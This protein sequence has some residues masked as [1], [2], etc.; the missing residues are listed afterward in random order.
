[1]RHR[2]ATAATL[3]IVV[4]AFGAGIFAVHAAEAPSAGTRA[5]VDSRLNRLEAE[6]SAAEDV[7][8]I[9]RLQRIYGYYV[10][11]GMWEDLGAF[12]TEDAVANY[13]AGTF[14]GHDSIRQHLFMNVG[15]K[16][17]GEVGLGDNRLYNHMNIQPV[18]HLDAGGKT[19]Q[20]RWRAFATFGSLGGGATWAE[21]VYEMQ[22]AKVNGVWKI[23]R[24]DY[25]SG[26]GA[27][28]STG[29]VAPQGAANSGTPGPGNAAPSGAPPSAGANAAAPG[30]AQSTAPSAATPRPR[31]QLAHPADR[32][33]NVECDGFP[34][35]CIAPFHY[36]NPG[37]TAGG[38]V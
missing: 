6:V 36:E 38:T 26:F 11:K 16:K 31:R 27:P 23:S 19:A 1:M 24:L 12:F 7:Q 14:I 15:G 4:A 18:V 32:E 10:D 9:K 13:P 5:S 21:G 22:Y 2:V 8:A 25:Y 30:A 17:M 34:K 28:Y 29:W 37:T 20:G 33:R 3:A 35:A